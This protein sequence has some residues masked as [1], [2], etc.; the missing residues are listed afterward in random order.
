MIVINELQSFS[1]HNNNTMRHPSDCRHFYMQCKFKKTRLLP[2]DLF[3]D[4]SNERFSFLLMV[5]PYRLTISESRRLD[6]GLLGL[7][8]RKKMMRAPL[9]GIFDFH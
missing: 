6:A 4:Y 7:F 2:S 3:N 9:S 8:Q 1:K 5:G